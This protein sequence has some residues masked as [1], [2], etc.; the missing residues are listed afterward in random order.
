MPSF[1]SW[2]SRSQIRSEDQGYTV[3]K[4]WSQ[5]GKDIRDPRAWVCPRRGK[6]PLL[7]RSSGT[8]WGEG[9]LGRVV[10]SDWAPAHQASFQ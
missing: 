7:R 3:G 4:R 10:P 5:D 8:T 9:T 6:A 2:G 1:L